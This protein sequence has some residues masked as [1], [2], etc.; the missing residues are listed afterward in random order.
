M[1]VAARI[2]AGSGALCL[3]LTA[4]G[5]AQ[6]AGTTAGSTV[7][8][9]VSVDYSVGGIAQTAVNA[10]NSIVVDRRVTLTIVEPGNAATSVSPGQTTAV[11]TFLVTNTSNAPLDFGLTVA[12][13]IGGPGAHGGTDNFDAGAPATFIDSNANGVYDAGTDLAAAFLDELAA[14]ASRTVFI[15][16]GVPIAR[17]NGD[18]AVVTLTATAREAG[19]AGAQGI[20]LT[21][22]SGANTAAMDTVFADGAGA[23]DAARDGQFSAR[24]D[25]LVSA[26][27]LS[28]V[29]TS[30]PISDPAN[31]AANPKNIPGATIEYCIQVTNA[32]GGATAVAPTVTDPLPAQTGFNA[33]FGV[34]VDGTINATTGFCEGGTATGSFVGPAP[35]TVTGTL[36]NLAPGATRTLYFRATLN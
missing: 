14:D 2:A 18:I 33:G 6:A 9:T 5:T 30:R 24:D 29:K 35:G 15:V 1:R 12:Q 7:V 32:S 4:A 27:L 19:A 17:I 3:A 8:N 36:A 11:T 20:V 21:Q 26:A 25:Y 28:V 22:T 16:S 31:G 34:F 23:T 13:P 10:S